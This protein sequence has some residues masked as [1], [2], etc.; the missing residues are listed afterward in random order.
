MGEKVK[1]LEEWGL[2]EIFYTAYTNSNVVVIT[3]KGRKVASIV[4]SMLEIIDSE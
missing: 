4:R 3:E 1:M 2:V